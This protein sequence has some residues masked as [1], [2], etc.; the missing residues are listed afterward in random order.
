PWWCCSAGR[1]TVHQRRRDAAL[2]APGLFACPRD[3]SVVAACPQ[4][5]GPAKATEQNRQAPIASLAFPAGSNS[6]IGTGNIYLLR[7]VPAMNSYYY[8]RREYNRTNPD[9]GFLALLIV[10]ALLVLAGASLLTIFF[11]VQVR[12]LVEISIYL[13]ALLAASVASLRHF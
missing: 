6:C 2:L 7:F 9:D 8:G 5:G 13:L 12:Q 10:V 3:K 4:G 11:H 1:K